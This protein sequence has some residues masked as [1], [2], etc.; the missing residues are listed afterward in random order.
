MSRLLRSLKQANRELAAGEIQSLDDVIAE[1]EIGM[2]GT[3]TRRTFE[4]RR[5]PRGQKP[6]WE[7]KLDEGEQIV[8]VFHEWSNDYATRETVDHFLSVYILST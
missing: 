5:I 3:I 4:V 1:F 6:V 7:F 2:T 8:G